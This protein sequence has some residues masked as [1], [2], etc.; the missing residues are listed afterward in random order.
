MEAF[1]CDRINLNYFVGRLWRRKVLFSATGDRIG[2]GFWKCR[3]SERYMVLLRCSSYSCWPRKFIER[4]TIQL[5]GFLL[6]VG[7]LLTPKLVWIW[8]LR[9]LIT[10][11]SRIFG[12]GTLENDHTWIDLVCF[13]VRFFFGG[14]PTNWLDRSVGWD[15]LR[16]VH[17]GNY[18]AVFIT[19]VHLHAWLRTWLSGDRLSVFESRWTFMLLWQPRRGDLVHLRWPLLA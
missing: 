13:F 14:R 3:L 5:N 16:L 6:Q 18:T 8:I 2:R 1:I 10:A 15:L 4:F 12:D 17:I 11:A 9:R 19:Y 7:L